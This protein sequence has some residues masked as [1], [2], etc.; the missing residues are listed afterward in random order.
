MEDGATSLRLL[1]SSLLCWISAGFHH[2]ISI[3]VLYWDEN[4]ETAYARATCTMWTCKHLPFQQRQEAGRVSVVCQ[5]ILDCSLIRIAKKGPTLCF[6][7][8]GHCSRKQSHLMTLGRALRLVFLHNIFFFTH[9]INLRKYF[10]VS[11]QLPS[12]PL[13]LWILQD[14]LYQNIRSAVSDCE[15]FHSCSLLFEVLPACCIQADLKPRSMCSLLSK[16]LWY[17]DKI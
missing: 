14:V 6:H 4:S 8:W 7:S 16:S 2:R 1:R 17:S 10:G 12:I 5:V 11:F 9:N 13:C 15:R 3:P